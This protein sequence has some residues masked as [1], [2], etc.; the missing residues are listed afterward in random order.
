MDGRNMP[1]LTELETVLGLEATN[2]SPLRGLA[3]MWIFLENIFARRKFQIVKR[4]THARPARKTGA[5]AEMNQ[6]AKGKI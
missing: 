3:V 1:L 2:M 4:K 6:S 5:G